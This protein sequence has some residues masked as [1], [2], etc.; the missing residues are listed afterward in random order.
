MSPRARIAVLALALLLGAG[1]GL[2]A[3]SWRARQA[4][5]SFVWPDAAGVEALAAPV[6]RRA[7]EEEARGRLCRAPLSEELVRRLL[8]LRGPN[9]VYDPHAWFVSR[10]GL[11]RLRPWPEHPA[12]EFWIRTN[13]LGM[14]SDREPAAS[15]AGARVL[16][17]GD[18]HLAGVCSNEETFAARLEARLAELDGGATP[19][20]IEVWNGAEGAYGFYQ[21]LGTLER[22]LAL[23]LVP[24]VLVVGAYAGNDFLDVWLRHFFHGTVA[25]GKTK[26][27]RTALERAAEREPGA[28]GQVVNAA[29]WFARGGPDEVARALAMAREVTSEIRRVARERD[30]ELVV[31]LL[32]APSEV[33]NAADAARIDAACEILGLEAADIERISGMADDYL[34]WLRAEGIEAVDLRPPFRSHAGGKLYW[35][36]DLHLS[37]AGHELAAQV[38]GPAVLAR[39]QARR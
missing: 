30:V 34:E 11:E 27:Q 21:Y 32:P 31:V 5:L 18:S 23:D 33:P 10:G 39:L 6:R 25:P 16:V 4:L 28:T 22:M 14:R 13:S 26:A 35:N 36:E 29:E 9:R 38:V 2:V 3:L 20:G 12:G 8:P 37:L 24:D 19:G 17:A 15:R 7:A 1:L